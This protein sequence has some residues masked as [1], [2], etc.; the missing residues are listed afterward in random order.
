VA[1]H[2]QVCEASRKRLEALRRTRELVRQLPSEE[3]PSGFRDE[4]FRTL[5]SAKSE[6]DEASRTDVRARGG[7]DRFLTLT[8][9]VAASIIVFIMPLAALVTTQTVNFGGYMR[10]R[11]ASEEA[12]MRET[13]EGSVGIMGAPQEASEEAATDEDDRGGELA[14]EAKE[15]FPDVRGEA[16][17]LRV[18][19]VEGASIALRRLIADSGGT[20]ESRDRVFDSGG[21]LTRTELVGSTPPEALDRVMDGVRDIGVVTER[22]SRESFAESGGPAEIVLVV[23][24]ARPPS[25]AADNEDIVEEY[26]FGDS[27]ELGRE[28]ERNFSGSW[29]RFGTSVA[30]T[31]VW[32]AGHL[33][34]LAFAGGLLLLIAGLVGKK[35][36]SRR[37]N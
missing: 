35:R 25:L 18:P 22:R 32:I 16:Y 26:A 19:D 9:L 24:R 13:P 15:D 20:L 28:L 6:E 8:A 3:T 4:L 14:S 37:S 7:R 1:E 33:P 17:T 2:V 12:P 29:Q 30:S 10:D 11:V 5:A 23:E 27:G 34:H 36:R 31:L 21:N